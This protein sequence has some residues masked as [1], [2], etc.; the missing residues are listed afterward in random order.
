MQQS[1]SAPFR[2][3]GDTL[4]VR[5]WPCIGLGCSNPCQ[6]I[7]VV[8]CV[9]DICRSLDQPS[10]LHHSPLQGLTCCTTF[11]WRKIKI[12]ILT[13]TIGFLA[14]LVLGNVP[15]CIRVP[16]GLAPW[17]FSH[18][19]IS[20]AL[21]RCYLTCPTAKKPNLHRLGASKHNEAPSMNQMHLRLLF[22]FSAN[23]GPVP[24]WPDWLQ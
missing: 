21:L 20:H 10:K 4:N 17:L 7:Y 15:A 22:D 14:L 12:E 9:W 3:S 1:V 8:F 6:W 24:F 5:H 16:S 19:S 13:I 2:E 11:S 23:I 18:T